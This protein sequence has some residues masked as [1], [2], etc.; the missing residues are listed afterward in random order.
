MSSAQ[1]SRLLLPILCL[2]MALGFFSTAI[3]L[4]SFPAIGDALHAS[5]EQVQQTLALFFLGSAIGSLILGPL[6]DRLGRL[7]VAKGGI[8]LFILTSFWCA[9]SHDIFSLQIARFLQGFAAGAGPLVV[10]AMGRDL[11]EGA[12]LTRFSATTM[13]VAS[14]SPAIAPTL[15]GFLQ[16]AVGWK[17]NFYFLMG[18]GI[19]IAVMVWKWLPETKPSSEE[20]TPL[21][22]ILKNY[23]TLFKDPSYTLFCLVIGLQMGALFCYV[24]FSPYLFITHFNFSPEEYGAL[25]IVGAIGNISGFNFARYLAHRIQFHQGILIGSFLSLCSSIIFLGICLLF[26]PTALTVILFSTGFY[27]ASALAVVNASTAAMNLFPKIAGVASAMVGS[28]QI[29]SGF[30]GSI[31]ASFLPTTPLIL[32]IVLTSMMFLSLIASF[33]IARKKWLG[34]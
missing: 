24:T 7:V 34:R 9:E 29:G 11:Y 21:S 18:F 22:S 25:G 4:P 12:D 6:A 5:P 13:M 17:Y 23:V 20:K 16:S 26:P 14:F 32:A 30:I 1:S 10:R 33:F 2:L 8:I 19:I 28:I 27:A 31:L 3:Y 15:G